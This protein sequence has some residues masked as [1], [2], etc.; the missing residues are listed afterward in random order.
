[1]AKHQKNPVKAGTSYERDKKIYRVGAGHRLERESESA[2]N[3][4]NAVG[5]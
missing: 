1:M 5:S 4:L 2:Q 3:P